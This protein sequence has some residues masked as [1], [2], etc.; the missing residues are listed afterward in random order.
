[1]FLHLQEPNN[2]LARTPIINILKNLNKV[3]EKWRTSLRN[4]GGGYV[5]HIYYWATMCPGPGEVP[6]ALEDKI[7]ETFPAGMTEF[8]ESFTAASLSLFGSGYVWLVTDDEENLR[9][10][11]TKDQVIK[12]NNI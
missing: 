9:I 7:K 12:I 1:M 10:I 2:V 6:R 11:S 3:P 5:N 8:K 4:N